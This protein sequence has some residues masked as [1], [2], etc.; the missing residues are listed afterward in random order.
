MLFNAS[1]LVPDKNCKLITVAANTLSV[2][3]FFLKS[4]ATAVTVPPVAK[5]SSTII[6]CVP[7]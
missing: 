6:G 7:G 3:K 2:L 5:R 4:L 1:T